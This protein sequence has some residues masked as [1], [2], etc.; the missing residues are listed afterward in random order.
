MRYVIFVAPFP[1]ATTMRFARAVTALKPLGTIGI[2]QEPPADGGGFDHIVR[3]SDVTSPVALGRALD[4]VLARFGRPHRLVGILESLQEGLALQRL[5]LGIPGLHP[6]AALRFRDKDEMKRALRGAGVPVAASARCDRPEQAEAFVSQHGF[7]AVLKPLAG[8]GAAATVRVDDAAGLALAL[9]QVPRPLII[10]SFLTGEEHS[11]ETWWLDGR[12][13]FSSVS[14]YRPTPLQVASNPHLQ[15]VVHLPRDERP[16]A[17]A[18]RT[19]LR[20]VSALGMDAGIAHTEWFRRPTGE[21]AIGEI[22]ARP[23][24]A[25]FMDLHV[26]AHDADL[27]RA[28]ARLVVDGV[29]EGPYERRW[30]VAGVYLRGPGQ[31]R[32]AAVEGLEEAQERMGALV[33]EA[34][35]PQPGRPRARGYEGDGFVIVKH[36]EDAVVL[37]AARILIS[38]LKVRYR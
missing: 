19:V 5:R 37:E 14:R 34:V 25:R 13:V 27:Y 33:A 20:A 29:W 16:F 30:S 35:L 8:S 4:G 6:E 17:D 38:T 36:A 23:P 22:A 3:C 21:V 15:W 10:E 2:F 28:W 11:L 1:M 26:H 7:P 9:R 12:P 24:G 31:G 32:V 18:Q